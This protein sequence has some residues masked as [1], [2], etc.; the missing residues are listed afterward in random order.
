[1]SHSLS[2]LHSLSPSLNFDSFPSKHLT[3]FPS[4]HLEPLSDERAQEIIDKA[5]EASSLKTRN[6]VA[7]ITGL[8]GAGKTWLLSRIFNK[9]PPDIYSSTGVIEQSF[10]GL[11]HHV[12]NMAV[13]SWQPFSHKDILEFLA[14]RFRAG[15]PLGNA[16]E[17]ASNLI[18]TYSH[19]SAADDPVPLPK[20]MSTSYSTA[21]PNSSAVVCKKPS[22]SPNESITGQSMVSLVKSNTISQNQDILELVHMIDTG[23]QPECME[24][25]PSLI[26]NC[27]LAIL[28]LNLMFGLDDY[29]PIHFHEKGK[30]YKR[31]LP[32]Q[33]T[34]KQIIQKLAC[35]LQAKRFSQKKDQHFHL[36]VVGTHKDCVLT[37]LSARLEDLERE[38]RNVLLPARKNELILFSSS[39]KI[40]FVLNLK[41]PDIDDLSTLELI[42]Q[43]ISQS[44]VGEIIDIP[45][46]FLIF[47][48]DILKHAEKVGRG[49][50]SLDEC[51]QVGAKLKMTGEVVM[52]AL[53]FF[54]R[55]ITFLHFQHVLPTLVF[56]KP[57]LPLDFINALVLFNYKVKAGDFMGFSVEFATNLKDGII[58]EEML[59]HEYLS[60]C[61]ITNLYEP[62]HALKLFR[63]TFTIAPLTHLLQQ[64][65][66][67]QVPSPKRQKIESVSQKTEYLMMSL[68]PALQ[69]QE[70]LNH[71]PAKSEVAPLIVKFSEDRVPLSCFSSTISCLL[72]IYDWKLCRREDG[73]P[74][75]LFH[76]VVSL[77]LSNFPGQIVLADMGNYF[78]IHIC[79]DEGIDPANFYGIY[80]RVQET[81]FAAIDEVFE[82][83]QLTE[84]DVIP[85][86]T[87]PCHRVSVPHS[88]SV[89]SFN[90][91]WFLRCSKTEMSVG[92]AQWMHNVWLEAPTP[93]KD[94]PS[95]PTLLRLKI[96]QNVGSSYKDFGIFLLSDDDGCR[97]DAIIIEC[98]GVVDRIV[99]R[100]LQEWVLGRGKPPTWNTLIKTL[101]NCQLNVL[102]DKVQ[103]FK[104]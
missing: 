76:N 91:R 66:S 81:V 55:Q 52:A 34:N 72:S 44:N 39:G 89:F 77:Y 15:M 31:A 101:K 88:A 99:I 95:L 22:S 82:I 1:M 7:V 42:R 67:L 33:Y 47:E 90:T 50:L 9:P 37:D 96:H 2:T 24:T 46:C 11:L 63:Y 41:N 100:I 98:Q 93:E 45:G 27:H 104:Q 14:S 51:M 48:Q 32:S 12:G 21:S 70:I 64:T 69:E 56:V 102:A 71:L 18:T 28:V 19:A 6:V 26:H 78:E 10:R 73:S 84:M 53:I 86:F 65:D 49:I 5:L 62:H 3:L 75:N 60:K 85:A 68:L 16:I 25:M 43:E 13:G 61:F 103:K 74:K 79:T 97:I 17:L 38:L 40:T 87:C 36:L 29:P 4:L 30:A 92:H 54:H 83:L 23:G 58:T 35:T 20:P 57:Q 80:F 59:H 8:T 94:K